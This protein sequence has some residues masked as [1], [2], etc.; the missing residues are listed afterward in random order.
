MILFQAQ[1][2]EHQTLAEHYRELAAKR[3]ALAAGLLAVQQQADSDL[4][5]LRQLVDK[6]SL[7][8][9]GA[10]AQ[11]KSAVL[12]LFIGE[13]NNGS[14]G[15]N[16]PT[17]PTPDPDGD[18]SQA[19]IDSEQLDEEGLTESVTCDEGQVEI[20]SEQVDEEEPELLCLNGFTGDCLTSAD[21]DETLE[22]QECHNTPLTYTQ[23]IK[24]RCSACWGYEVRSKG[25]IKS[26][27]VNRANLNFM[28][29]VNLERTGREF[30]KVVENYLNRLY[31]TGQS[32]E[33]ASPFASPVS[34]DE[35]KYP[36]TLI[37]GSRFWHGATW[38]TG[39]VI[40]VLGNDEYLCQFDGAVGEVELDRPSLHY[41]PNS[42]AGQH[43]DIDQAPKIGQ[44]CD[45]ACSVN[46]DIPQPK[47]A[48]T[49][50]VHTSARTGYLKVKAS[51]QILAAY[52]WFPRKDLAE[53][54]FDWLDGMS[55]GSSELRFTKRNSS[56]KYEIKLTGLSMTQI[57]RLSQEDLGRKPS[58]KKETPAQ[59]A[60][61][62]PPSGWRQPQLKE[63]SPQLF[64]KVL[65]P[66]PEYYGQVLPVSRVSNN[67]IGY[68]LTLPNGDNRWYR[69]DMV[70]IVD[71]EIEEN[72]PPTE[73]TQPVDEAVPMAEN[74]QKGEAIA[75][76]FGDIAEVTADLNGTHLVGSFG[77]V[78]FVKDNRIALEIDEQLAYFQPEELKLRSKAEEPREQQQLQ[79]GQVLL[80]NR[81][82][83]TGAYIGSARRTAIANARR[84]TAN[85]HRS[86]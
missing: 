52:A 30:Y 34:F 72:A 45:W 74:Q 24:N 82:V 60:G 37:P 21:L 78:K 16:H 76:E 51:G 56:W 18:E 23:A 41:I 17:D 14:E 47:E 53:S 7:V 80:N 49:E 43:S 13:D 31:Y 39:T 28:E 3:E 62:E 61:I 71:T 67:G 4:W 8:A 11:L 36:K 73:P 55:L 79:T 50:M 35:T 58:K 83:T 33:W 42:L 38:S 9:P 48:S 1:I 32:C 81:V 2:E 19:A 12:E 10:I 59:A 15:G 25:D 77:K 26:G 75:F 85:S 68:T 63:N 70:Q 69:A 20:A 6:C 65:L 22:E 5:S 29:A 64:A 54:W 44:K 86:T 27:F 84:G 66:E 57:E 40:K 46:F